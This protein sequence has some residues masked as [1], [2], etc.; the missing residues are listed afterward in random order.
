MGAD[1]SKNSGQLF[2]ERAE[3]ALFENFVQD[4]CAGE[5]DRAGQLLGFM[6]RLSLI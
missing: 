1:T 5:Y 3:G 4:I 6:E 2:L